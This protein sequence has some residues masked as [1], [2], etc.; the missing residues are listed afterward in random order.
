MAPH[1]WIPLYDSPL[2]GKSKPIGSTSSSSVSCSLWLGRTGVSCHHGAAMRRF[3]VNCQDCHMRYEGD[4]I[5]N[6]VLVGY[7][8]I[9]TTN[10]LSRMNLIGWMHQ[11]ASHSYIR[12]GEPG[13]NLGKMVEL[14]RR[15]SWPS[16]DAVRWVGGC[17][18]QLPWMLRNAAV[19]KKHHLDRR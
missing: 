8:Q 11:H 10:S 17:S 16:Q 1:A 7:F 6:L 18:F 4:T 9:W 14:E 19:T 15:L 3:G 13:G 12:N 2:S 5:E